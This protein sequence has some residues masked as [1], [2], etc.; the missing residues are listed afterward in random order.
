VDGRT[1]PAARAAPRSRYLTVA[2][3]LAL[4]LVTAAC[5][6]SS[7]AAS[8]IPTRQPQT[9]TTTAVVTPTTTKRVVPTTTA[10]TL[11][12]LAVPAVPFRVG[13]RTFDWV[14][15][16]RSTPA[17][18]TYP[19]RRGRELVTTIW[20]PAPGTTSPVVHTGATPDRARGPFPVV[21]FAHGHGGEP[22]D[23]FADLAAWASRGYVVVAPAFPLSRRRALGGPTFADL[24]NQP[25]DLSYALTRV[26]AANADTSSWLHGMIDPRRVGAAGHSEGAWTVLALVGNTCCRDHRITAAIILA[27]EMSAAF[28]G[29]FYKSGAPPMLFVDAVDD[30]TVPYANGK[31]A[32]LAA[33]RPK[34]LLTVNIG[35]HITPYSGPKKPEGAVVLRVTNEFLDRYLRRVTTVAITSPDLHLATIASRL[36]SP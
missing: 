1:R 7:S 33:P 9:T 12:P 28:K 19:G 35:D 27:G 30:P 20:Y 6:G 5:A 16:S 23:Y 3:A 22:A 11:P 24:P 8:T 26:L 14:D 25:A 32:Y 21:L 18:G 17:N 13:S 29:R 36:S 31:A 2:P 4:A 34:Y 10:S 15:W